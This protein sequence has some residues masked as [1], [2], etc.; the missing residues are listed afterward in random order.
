MTAI[1]VNSRLVVKTCEPMEGLSSLSCAAP[2]KSPRFNQYPR[3]IS[4]FVASIHV[5]RR[6]V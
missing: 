2:A 4:Y 6:N 5:H 3:S 1:G